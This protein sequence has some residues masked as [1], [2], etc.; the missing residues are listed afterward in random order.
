MSTQLPQQKATT[1]GFLAGLLEN[2]HFLLPAFTFLTKPFTSADAFFT[3][4]L[5][6]TLKVR[7]FSA[8]TAL[9]ENGQSEFTGVA[10]L[11][12]VKK[13]AIDKT[14]S[15]VRDL[16]RV[17]FII[18]SFYFTEMRI[19]SNKHSHFQAIGGKSPPPTTEARAGLIFSLPET[20]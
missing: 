16:L 7:T 17:I 11:A 13:K 14:L 2:G 19:S 3:Q 12:A 5:Q 9:P 18:L 8:L 15:K 20:S 10:F 4:L 1:T 6:H